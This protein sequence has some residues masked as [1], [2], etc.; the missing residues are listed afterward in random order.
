MDKIE[1]ALAKLSKKERTQLARIFAKLKTGALGN[2][3]IKKLKGRGDVFR[4]RRGNMRVFYIYSNGKISILAVER[5][6]DT[7]YNHGVSLLELIIYV[8]LFAV[9]SALFIG[10][11]FHTTLGWTRSKVESE[12]QQNLRFAME[13]ITRTVR[14]AST[15]GAPAVGASGSSLSVT[16]PLGTVTYSLSG[17]ALEKQIGAD[18]TQTLTT[19][20]VNVTRLYFLT[21]QNTA[22]SNTAVQ[23]TSTQFAMTVEYNSSNNQFEYVQ[24]ATST[25]TLK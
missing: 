4:V 24:H 3:D 11:L 13:D 2:L 5:R 8:G 19:D 23:A 16:T 7:T 20:K 22:D 17:T 14:S 6:S 15:V 1:K 21:L 10:I 12:V 25:A 9:I 18:P